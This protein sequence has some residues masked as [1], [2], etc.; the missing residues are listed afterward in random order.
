[1]FV[2]VSRMN[3]IVPVHELL[4][5]ITYSIKSPLTMHTHLSSGVRGLN[6]NLSLHLCPHLVR[7]SSKVS[8]QPVQIY[9]LTRV[10]MLLMYEIN[11]KFK[12]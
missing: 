8:G 10:L 2:L 5:L 1:M 9:S 6:F 7:V 4:V 3:I 12:L 11:T